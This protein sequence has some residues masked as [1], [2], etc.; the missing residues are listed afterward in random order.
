M[1][2]SPKPNF[3]KAENIKFQSTLSKALRKP[4]DIIERL[5]FSLFDTSIISE[6]VDSVCKI[7]LF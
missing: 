1:E 3:C 6:I 5:L 7:V 2:L 4:S